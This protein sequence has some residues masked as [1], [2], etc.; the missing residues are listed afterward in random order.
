MSILE[1]LPLIIRNNYLFLKKREKSIMGIRN[2][3]VHRDLAIITLVK[4][5]TFNPASIKLLSLLLR[6][7][8]M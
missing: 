1:A 4:I 8:H 7:K 2:G 6:D 3:S 5:K